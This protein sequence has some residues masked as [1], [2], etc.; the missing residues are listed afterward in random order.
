MYYKEIVEYRVTA[1]YGPKAGRRERLGTYWRASE[2]LQELLA[3]YLILLKE[4]GSRRPFYM[5][6]TRVAGLEGEYSHRICLA[7]AETSL[8][9]G[10]G[11]RKAA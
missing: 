3:F 5:S 10:V 1:V 9:T 7:L 6:L 4:R 11:R 2:A 8:L